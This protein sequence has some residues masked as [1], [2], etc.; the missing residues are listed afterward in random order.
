MVSASQLRSGMVVRYENQTY[1]VVAAEYHPGQGKMGGVSHARLK[2]LS[3]GTFWEHSFR[4]ELKLEEVASDKRVMTFLYRD[5]DHCYFMDPDTYEQIAISESMVGPQ[6]VFILPE[7]RLNIELVEGAPVGV[8]FP[9]LMEVRIADTA[10]PIH[11]QQ[12]S[13]WK[14]A[15]LE[16]GME[17]MVPHFIKT[18]DV[19]R[20]DV[21]NLK[22]VDRAKGTTK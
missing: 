16:N 14:P 8:Q 13:T 18:G 11:Q 5:G 15:R 19:V 20:I 7:M 21:E 2:N 6:A 12:D 17:I 4:S 3:T 22:Y 9:E 10:P 1:R